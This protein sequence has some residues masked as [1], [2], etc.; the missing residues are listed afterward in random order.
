MNTLTLSSDRI[1]PSELKLPLIVLTGLLLSHL[2]AARPALAYEAQPEVKTVSLPAEP[3]PAA[4]ASSPT[5]FSELLR[6]LLMES[7][8]ADYVD[9]RD[10]RGTVER[11]DGFQTRGLRISKR[12]REVPHGIWRRYRATLIQPEKNFD[13]QVAQLPVTAEG[14][15]PFSILISLRARCE[16]TFVW[17]TYGVKGM[18]GTAI[19]DASLQL[20]ILLETSPRLAFSLEKPIPHLELRPKVTNVELRLKDLDLRRLGVFHGDLIKVLGDGST[21]AVEALIRQQEGKIRD[22]LQKGLDKAGS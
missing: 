10:W 16:A 9:N 7:M 14:A 11:F 19:S 20:Q 13:V 15:V 18:N 2:A 3:L 8:K 6:A 22:Q 17:W 5:N 1:R 12:E 4:V 21:K